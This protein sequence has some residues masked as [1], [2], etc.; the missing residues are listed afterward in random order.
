MINYIE[1]GPGLHETIRQAGQMLRHENG[2]WISSDDE[3]V[4]L[5]IDTYSLAQ[6]Q[7]RKSLEISAHAKT[8]R[9]KVVS[10]ISAGE[11]ASW[12][13]K[14]A[15]A[16]RFNV[17]ADPAECPMLSLEAQA[18]GITLAELVAKVNSNTERFSMAEAAIGGTDGK[19]RDAVPRLEDFAA[20]ANYDYSTGW[21]EV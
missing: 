12:S 16:A 2:G 5:I 8:L 10:A 21:P 14:A 3:I 17:S 6:A 1:K 4:Q 11:M 9:D 19:H 20:I 18:R 15:E 13:V 7:A